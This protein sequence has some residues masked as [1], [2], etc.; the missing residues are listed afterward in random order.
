MDLETSFARQSLGPTPTAFEGFSPWLPSPAVLAAAGVGGSGW[1]QMDEK[2]EE[3]VS[4]PATGP[5]AAANAAPLNGTGSGGGAGRTGSTSSHSTSPSVYRGQL[6]PPD[7]SNMAALHQQHSHYYYGGSESGG[8]TQPA[9]TLPRRSKYP[10]LDTVSSVL[11]GSVPLALAEELLETYFSHSTHVLAYLVRRSSVL[12]LVNPR[13]TS[14]SLVFAMLM[15]AAHHSDHPSLTGSPAARPKMIA[16]LTELTIAHLRPAFSVS[17]PGTLDDVIT[18]IQIATIVSASEHKG[19]S[20]RWWAIAWDLAKE[21]KLNKEDPLLDVERREEQRRTWW[22]LY[23]VDRHLGLCYNRPLV[24][25]DAESQELYR[26]EDEEVWQAD[27]AELT[28]PELAPPGSRVKGVCPFVTGQGIYGW[29]LPIMTVLGLLVDMHHLEQNALLPAGADASKLLRANVHTYLEQ[30]LMSVTNWN[31]VPCRNAYENAWRDYAIQLAHVLHV[32]FYVP[33]DPIQLLDSSADLMMSP[34]FAKIEH[35]AIAAVQSI[36]RI[37]AVDPD[38]MLM[39]FFIGIYLLQGS[40]VLLAIVDQV[41][42]D[43]AMEV[44]GACETIVRAHEVCIVTLNTEY[45]RNFRRIMRGTMA[46]LQGDHSSSVPK[47]ETRRRQ[48]DVLGLY[49]WGPGGRG[50]AIQ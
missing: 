31:T 41:Q 15:V 17:E 20:L 5:T 39:P 6:S 7:E 44:V 34:D 49:N 27:D 47:D 19:T 32:L 3:K 18:Y 12:S 9:P 30:Y 11:E 26:P 22:L 42:T 46:L 36:R 4:L 40:F 1:F 8:S 33:W 2:A 37:L 16:R 48:R 25:L 38:M 50:L 35:H 43:A 14:P 24:I 29:F 21:L 28:P 13:P 10:L 23:M 45:Q